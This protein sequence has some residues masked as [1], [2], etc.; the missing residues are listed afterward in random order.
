[1]YVQFPPESSTTRVDDD[2]IRELTADEDDPDDDGHP[3]TRDGPDDDSAIQ[4]TQA[5]GEHLID[6][7]GFVENGETDTNTTTD[8]AETTDEATASTEDA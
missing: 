1:M 4:V 5:L 8:T 2:T 6:Q 7:W 3:I